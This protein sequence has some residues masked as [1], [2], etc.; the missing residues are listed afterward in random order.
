ME[1]REISAVV[2]LGTGHNSD[3]RS[4]RDEVKKI[5]TPHVAARRDLG[6][7]L[8]YLESIDENFHDKNQDSRQNQCDLKLR[9]EALSHPH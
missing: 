1:P 7:S 9:E 2:A 5:K 3:R 6:T 8:V 4:V